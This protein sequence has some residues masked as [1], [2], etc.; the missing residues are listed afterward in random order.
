MALASWNLAAS[1]LSALAAKLAPTSLSALIP[2]KLAVIPVVAGLAVGTAAGASFVVSPSYEPA[3][4]AQVA[5]VSAPAVM[6]AVALPA[7]PAPVSRPCETQTWPYLDSRCMAGPTQEKRVRL[8]NAPR[9]GEA[10]NAATKLPD[11]MITGDTVLRQPQ[12]IDAI[13]MAETKPATREK[14][15]VTRKRDRRIATQTYQ[16]PS[17]YGQTARPVIVVRPMRLDS[18]R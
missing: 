13:P 15:K 14:R 8:V 1:N 11:G 17:E 6:P 3:A 10:A 5:A 9:P 4:K 18:F 16:V 7:A 12:N 2:A